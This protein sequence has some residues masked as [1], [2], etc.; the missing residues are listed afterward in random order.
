MD[1]KGV[2]AIAILHEIAA[3]KI[4]DIEWWREYFDPVSVEYK[5]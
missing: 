1:N 4:S 5:R 3:P 2:H